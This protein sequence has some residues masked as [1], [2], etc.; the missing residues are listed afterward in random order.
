MLIIV[1]NK[2]GAKRHRTHF[3]AYYPMVCGGEFPVT[4]KTGV[5][6]FF[7]G[8]EASTITA[9][10]RARCRML[11]PRLKLFKPLKKPNKSIGRKLTSARR[12]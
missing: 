4:G 8:I 6:P 2:M 3:F 11:K 10:A 12:R 7:P 1:R 5:G 9:I